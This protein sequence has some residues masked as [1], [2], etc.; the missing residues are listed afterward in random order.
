MRL[1]GVDP[2]LSDSDLAPVLGR[3]AEARVVGLGEATHGDRESFQ[4]KHRLIQALVRQQGF[5]VFLFESSPAEMER[6]DRY[7]TGVDERPPL[8]RGLHPW[9]TE[10][11][12]ELFTWLREWNSGR[13]TGDQVR[14]GGT[15]TNSWR[16]LPLAVRLLDEASIAAP[17]AW[18]RLSAEAEKGRF[19]RLRNREWVEGA[20]A[21]WHASE[22]PPL[23]GANPDHRWIAILANSFPQWLE[24]WSGRV[25]QEERWQLGDRYMALNTMAQL[26]RFGSAAKAML[27]AH[28]HHLWLE[29]WRAGTHLRERLGS[30]YRVVYCAFGRGSSN[31]QPQV[32]G[33]GSTWHPHPCPPPPPGSMEYLL[34]QLDADCYAVEPADVPALR[35]ELPVRHARMVVPDGDDQ[36]YLR[37]VPAERFDLLVYFRQAHP[38]RMLDVL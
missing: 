12:R 3:L 34:D 33:G 18:R 32:P 38:A 15:T 26:E 14:V 9:C 29:S 19:A 13:A 7:V 22:S 6:Y 11:V 37:C 17:P 1:D 21:T 4:F 28:N 36:F 27:W 23:D 25:P 20:L 16:G 31:A 8:D 5:R 30:G 35:R 2:A 24:I 10:E